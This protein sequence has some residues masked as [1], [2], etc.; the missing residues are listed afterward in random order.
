MMITEHINNKLESVYIETL[1]ENNYQNIDIVQLSP[2]LDLTRL[3][4]IDC[5]GLALQKVQHNLR[6]IVYS[7]CLATE[8]TRSYRSGYFLIISNFQ[9]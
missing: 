2:K 4:R 5:L 7:I 1:N 6:H 8:G 3:A 9:P